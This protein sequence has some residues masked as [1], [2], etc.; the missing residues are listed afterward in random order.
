MLNVQVPIQKTQRQPENN[1]GEGAS[2]D[3]ECAREVFRDTGIA[4]AVERAGG[5]VAYLN[6][7]VHV[8]IDI[9]DGLVLKSVSLPKVLLDA[10]VF[11]SV[12]KMKTH[13][14]TLVTL[15]IKKYARNF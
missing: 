9:P 15:G 1:V 8:D 2:V 10:D 7:E 13:L 6:E 14:M 3:V 11:I 5:E 12:P 4:E